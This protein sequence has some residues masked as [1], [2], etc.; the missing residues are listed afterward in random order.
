MLVEKIQNDVKEKLKKYN[1]IPNNDES[2]N[3]VVNNFSSEVAYTF[4]G[5]IKEHISNSVI[6]VANLKIGEELTTFNKEKMNDINMEIVFLKDDVEQKDK[7]E[8][9][10]KSEASNSNLLIQAKK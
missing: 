6:E 1:L 7:I 4:L 3:D 2:N 10:I 5:L 8:L 9:I